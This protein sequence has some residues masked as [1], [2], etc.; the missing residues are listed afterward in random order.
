MHS[1]WF[2]LSE[3][4]VSVIM[5]LFIMCVL[6]RAQIGDE[7]SVVETLTAAAGTVCLQSLF[8]IYIQYKMLYAICYIRFPLLYS[9]LSFDPS[10]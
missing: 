2:S 8:V 3:N 9:R 4:N 1:E 5:C 6:W 7:E 10:H